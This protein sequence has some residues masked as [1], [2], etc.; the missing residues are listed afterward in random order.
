[1]SQTHSHHPG[2]KERQARRDQA[3]HRLAG[4]GGTTAAGVFTLLFLYLA[5]F[6]NQGW[7]TYLA[8]QPSNQL[9]WNV[10]IFSAFTIIF[11]AI[12]LVQNHADRKA[13]SQAIR[14]DQQDVAS[15]FS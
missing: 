15:A 11:L 4:I 8:G 10:A 12:T 7:T 6:I 14:Q 13:V 2:P 5:I 1:M 3:D 9:A